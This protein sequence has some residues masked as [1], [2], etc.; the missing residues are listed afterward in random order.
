MKILDWGKGIYE[1]IKEN[2]TDARERE[3]VEKFQKYTRQQKRHMI[4]TVNGE[5]IKALHYIKD[6]AKRM[7]AIGLK[8]TGGMI[9]HEAELKEIYM[10]LGRPGI[11]KYIDKIKY[12]IKNAA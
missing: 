1:T 7:P 4:L 10:Q 2:I 11:D 9:D 6:L 3:E 5:N 8:A 12:F